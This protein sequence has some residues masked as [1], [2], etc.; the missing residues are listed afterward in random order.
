MTYAPRGADLCLTCCARCNAFLAAEWQTLPSERSGAGVYCKTCKPVVEA[1]QAARPCVAGARCV[2]VDYQ[3]GPFADLVVREVRGDD[4]RV[5]VLGHP[6]G[7]PKSAYAIHHT[8][9]R[10]W[11]KRSELVMVGN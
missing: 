5:F 2:H 3:R 6:D 9:G 1:E 10:Q 8:V 4:V 11:F 7:V